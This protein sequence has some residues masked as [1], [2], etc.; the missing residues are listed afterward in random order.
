MS[1]NYTKEEYLKAFLDGIKKMDWWKDLKC[2]AGIHCESVGQS[3]FTVMSGSGL[4]D[5][6]HCGEEFKKNTYH[7]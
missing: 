5:C 3:S 1:K 6:L 2:W 7:E 4:R